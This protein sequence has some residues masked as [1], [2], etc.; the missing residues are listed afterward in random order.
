MFGTSLTKCFKF[1]E[2]TLYLGLGILSAYFM[3]GVLEKF[4]SNKSSFTQSEE[5]I[6]DFPVITICFVKPEYEYGSDFVIE[7]GFHKGNEFQSIILEERRTFTIFGKE[8]YLE[9]LI[10]MDLGNCYKISS[11]S[12]PIIKYYTRISIHFN[13]SILYSDL[14]SKLKVYVTSEKNSYGVVANA[15][16][17]GKSIKVEI[18]KETSKSIDLKPEKYNYIASN[19]C[20]QESF[21]ECFSR[22][23]KEKLEMHSMTK[24]SPIS[25][26]RLPMCKPNETNHEEFVAL[27]WKVLKEIQEQR[28]CP[29]LCTT[30]GYYG[31]ISTALNVTWNATFSFDYG[32][33]S[34]DTLREYKEYYI[35]D[36]VSMISSVGG[37][38]GMCVGFSF[39]GVISCL[40]NMVY[41]RIGKSELTETELSKI[42]PLNNSQNDTVQMNARLN[43]LEELFRTILNKLMSATVKKGP[44]KV[45]KYSK[46]QC[47]Y[48]LRKTITRKYL[49]PKKLLR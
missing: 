44:R 49:R 26:P 30:L 29:K 43:E 36:A 11:R 20:S 39:T 12:T 21:Y 13:E 28:K 18:E 9:K 35:Y 45:Y 46:I 25:L 42:K 40:F 24:C 38:L 1:I 32:F 8:V 17:N 31:K 2:W 27:S 37:T 3:W 5:P 47:R 22:S 34:S 15:W 23:Y 48:H 7:H 41:N 33:I 4:F 14:P 10:T 16:M 19:K 6:E